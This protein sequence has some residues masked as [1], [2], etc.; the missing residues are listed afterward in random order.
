MTRRF[1]VGDIHGAHRALLQVIERSGFDREHDELVSLGDVVDGWPDSYDCVEEL[2]ALD[3]VLVIGNHDQWFLDWM[4]SGRAEPAWVSQG[5]RATL[6]S[7][8][9]WAASGVPYRHRLFFEEAKPYH[10]MGQITDRQPDDMLFVHGGAPR[11]ESPVS[12]L[13]TRP[14]T[15]Q[16]DRSLIRD[17]FDAWSLRHPKRFGNW[18]RIFLGHT[19]LTSFGLTEPTHFGNVVGMDT[20]AGWEG[21]L[22]IM[23]IDTGQFWQSDV[24]ADL[25]P[26][27]RGRR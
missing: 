27:A 10:T 17:A 2:L 23:D 13:L 12:V 8:G 21:R 4:R 20:G 6:E 25:Y 9:Q 3:A 14:E 15:L 19:T 24:V 1:V 16:W 5:G 26:E 11:P 22:S 7:Y 18:Q